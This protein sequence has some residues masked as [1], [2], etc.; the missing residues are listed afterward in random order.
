MM[1]NKWQPI[2]TAPKD[3]TGILLYIPDH[4]GEIVAA[5][6]NGKTNRGWCFLGLESISFGF[7]QDGT[8][9]THWQHLPEPPK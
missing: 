1:E 7:D 2:E 9:P 6:W 5:I 4:T 8:F 3:K